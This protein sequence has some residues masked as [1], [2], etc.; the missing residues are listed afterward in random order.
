MLKTPKSLR[1]HIGVFGRMNVGKS[2]LVNMISGQ[3]VSITSEH[4]GTTTDVVEKSMELLPIGPVVFLDTAGIDDASQLGSLRTE[5][6]Q[7]I[8]SRCDALILV[9]DSPQWGEYEKQIAGKADTLRLPLQV[10]LNKADLLEPDALQTLKQNSHRDHI[11]S[12]CAADQ[13]LRSSYVR[14]IT[15]RLSSLL[16]PHKLEHP[17]ILGDLTGAN[18]HVVFI[19]PIDIEAPKGR[20]IL[21]QVQAIRDMLDHDGVVTVVKEHQYSQVLSD[22]RRKPDLV[23]CDSQVVDRMCEETPEDIPCTTF[24]TL[25]ARVKGD[26]RELVRGCRSPG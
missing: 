16:P 25:F 20:L 8:F 11:L 3:R 4:P 2:S 12:L 6:T 5:G 7:K 9:T 22:F 26:L 10:I 14:A 17:P 18:A 24:S 13:Q 19:V 15:L 23:V 1:P 21:P